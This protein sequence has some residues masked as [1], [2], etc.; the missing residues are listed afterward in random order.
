[1]RKLT[2][3]AF[4]TAMFVL[5]AG[6]ADLGALRAE[7]QAQHYSAILKP[8]IDYRLSLSSKSSSSIQQE[9]DYM[10][11][12]TF[13][14]LGSHRADGC[15][16][17][18]LLPAT[19]QTGAGGK[20]PTADLFTECCRQAGMLPPCAPGVSGKGDSA[21]KQSPCAHIDAK[22]DDATGQ[23]AGAGHPTRQQILQQARLK[24]PHS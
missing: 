21:S 16:Y 18:Q 9:A 7:F 10:V 14:A 4:A 17:A 11:A 15:G 1:M 23:G 20:R 19:L 8:L 6:A 2:L 3:G 13:C 22:T 5:A 12:T 24:P